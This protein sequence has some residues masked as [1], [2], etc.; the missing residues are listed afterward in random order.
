[1]YSKASLLSFDCQCMTVDLK[2]ISPSVIVLSR[3]P[4][5]C[6]G[7]DGDWQ[8]SVAKGLATQSARPRPKEPDQRGIC[9]ISPKLS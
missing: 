3:V 7:F 9:G 5:C 2:V 1:M 4:E 6:T 8:S